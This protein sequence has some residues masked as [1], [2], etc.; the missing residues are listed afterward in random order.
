ML[1]LKFKQM[2]KLTSINITLGNK[3]SLRKLNEREKIL[4]ENDLKN[5]GTSATLND[6]RRR[7]RPQFEK[8]LNTKIKFWDIKIKLN[9][10]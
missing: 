10:E 2:K 3:T 4:I 5:Y 1:L 7:L 8:L 9:F 6:I